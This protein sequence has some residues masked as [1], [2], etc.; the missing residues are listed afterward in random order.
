M[1]AAAKTDVEPPI[2]AKLRVLKLE[3]QFAELR[4]DM[5]PPTTQRD[6]ADT[7]EPNL[8][9]ARRLSDEPADL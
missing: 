4:I 3:P 5:L 6:T 7:P 8:A 9:T 1:Q 2:L